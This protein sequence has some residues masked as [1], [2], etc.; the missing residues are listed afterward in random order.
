MTTTLTPRVI[1]EIDID[2]PQIRAFSAFVAMGRWW[3]RSH[4]I[5][6][7]PMVDLTIEPKAG[8]RWYE[9]G[10]DGT[11][12]DWGRVEVYDPPSRLLLIWSITPDWTYDPALETEVEVTFTPTATGT[13][14][15]LEHRGLEAYGDRATEMQGI[16]SSEMGWGGLLASFAA[17]LTT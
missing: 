3:L 11:T 10:E 14:V 4:S 15:R 2:A 16:F 9:T 6:G 1:H 8:G 5:G 7:T 17:A 12:C 13:N